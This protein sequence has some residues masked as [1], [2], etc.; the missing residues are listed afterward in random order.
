MPVISIKVPTSTAARVA[1]MAAKRRVSKST[2]VREALDE[3][4]RSSTDEPSVHDVMKSQIGAVD[5][6]V[7]DRGHNPKHLTRFG[8]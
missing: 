6:G 4:L 3:K 2:I 1:R 7:R 5:S 8:R